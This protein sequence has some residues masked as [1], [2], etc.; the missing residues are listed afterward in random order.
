M[1]QSYPSSLVTLL[2]STLTSVPVLVWAQ[3]QLLLSNGPGTALP[4]LTL[5]RI[6]NTASTQLVVYNCSAI[7]WPKHLSGIPLLWEFSHSKIDMTVS[8][9]DQ[10]WSKKG[11]GI[12]IIRKWF[13]IFLQNAS[14]FFF[15]LH[16]CSF[17]F[18]CLIIYLWLW[19]WP[20]CKRWRRGL[21]QGGRWRRPWWTWRWTRGGSTTIF[22]PSWYHQS[23]KVLSILRSQFENAHLEAIIVADRVIGA[24]RHAGSQYSHCQVEKNSMINP[25]SMLALSPAKKTHD[26]FRVLASEPTKKWFMVMSVISLKANWALTKVFLLL[27]HMA[28]EPFGRPGQS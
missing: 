9:F 2:L 15:V 14:A 13:P 8:T 7:K 3:P 10:Q 24:L 11:N 22:F 27:G 5:A 17:L 1:L 16:I 4:L 21:W 23:F 26:N 6:L 18:F 25:L 28:T 20:S 12:F 19:H